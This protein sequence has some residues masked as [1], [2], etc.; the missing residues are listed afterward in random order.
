MILPDWRAMAM[1]VNMAKH[2]G[3]VCPR[4]KGSGMTSLGSSPQQVTHRRRMK[5][6][7]ATRRAPSETQCPR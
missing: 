3:W 7:K 1:G 4:P 6:T 2:R 5:R